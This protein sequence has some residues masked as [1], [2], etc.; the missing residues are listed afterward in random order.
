VA[1]I[2]RLG[3]LSIKFNDLPELSGGVRTP[4]AAR[5]TRS[6]RLKSPISGPTLRDLVAVEQRAFSGLGESG[7]GDSIWRPGGRRE[8]PPRL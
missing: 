7:I 1:Q 8:R 5:E 6:R 4:E 2:P 3:F